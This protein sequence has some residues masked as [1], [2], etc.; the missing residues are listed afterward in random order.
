MVAVVQGNVDQ[1]IKW[2][3][4]FQVITTVKHRNLSLEAAKAGADLVIWPETATPFYLFQ[5][6]VLTE[7]VIQG[8][9]EA[10]TYFIIGSPSVDT[11]HKEHVYYN[12]AY[13]ITPKGEPVGRYD[14]VHLVPFGEY[15]P[16]KRYLPFLGKMVAQVADFKAGRPGTPLVWGERPIGMLICYEIIFPGLARAMTLN[17]GQLLVNI[18]NDAWFGRTSAAYQHFS[19][20]VFRSIENR[21]FLAR[22]ANT[23]ISGFIDPNGRIMA[24]TGLFEDATLAAEVRFLDHLTAYTR[25]GD[26]PL[27]AVCFGLL[28]VG[29]VGGRRWEFVRQYG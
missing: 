2:D 11:D 15:V 8:V 1:S 12:S 4:A 16:L 14:K 5:D 18:T 21:R 28:A 20:A 7:M 17:G 26:W 19:M 23:G 27:M 29:L 25:W 10:G 22:A 24:A 6:Q 13:L 9:R 3:A